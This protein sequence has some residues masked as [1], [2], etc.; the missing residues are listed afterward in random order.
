[1]LEGAA[2][3]AFVRGPDFP[4]GGYIYGRGTVDDKDNVTACLMTMLLLK[5]SRIPLER[6]VIFLAESGEIGS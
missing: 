4:T 1:M 6:D 3:R 5:R 2:L